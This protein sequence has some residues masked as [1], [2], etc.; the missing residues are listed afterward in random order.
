MFGFFYFFIF[1]SCLPLR[2]EK[3]HRKLI[4]NSSKTHRKLDTGKYFYD[5]IRIVASE[6]SIEYQVSS[7]GREK[8]MLKKIADRKA[9][10]KRWTHFM[11]MELVG[12]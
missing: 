1:L 5:V 8:E 12:V 10:K 3:T 6:N 2:T 11:F 9:E 7:Q 4:V